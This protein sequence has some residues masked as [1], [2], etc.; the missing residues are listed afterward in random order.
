MATSQMKPHGARPR[1]RDDNDPQVIKARAYAIEYMHDF[2][3]GENRAKYLAAKK[4]YNE[5]HKEQLRAYYK[6]YNAKKRAELVALRAQ[7][8][9]LAAS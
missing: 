6:V 3:T 2:A 4:A 8:Q 9:A 5:R 1:T 7:V